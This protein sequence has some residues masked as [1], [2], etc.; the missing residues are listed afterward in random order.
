[1][2]RCRC[3]TYTTLGLSCS[4]CRPEKSY[5]KSSNESDSEVDE[6]LEWD[7]VEE[8]EVPVDDDD[9]MFD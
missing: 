5:Y 9:Q 2:I 8:T 4:R 6:T 7:K 3:G 1:M